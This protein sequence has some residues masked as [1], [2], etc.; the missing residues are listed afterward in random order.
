MDEGQKI[1]GSDEARRFCH[2]LAA[3]GLMFHRRGGSYGCR[4]WPGRVCKGRKTPGYHGDAMHTVQN[5]EIVEFILE[6][7]TAFADSFPRPMAA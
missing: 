2:G 6:N 7:I 4:E 5:L 3:H 1:S